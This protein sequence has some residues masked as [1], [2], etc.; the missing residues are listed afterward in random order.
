[1][2]K[3]ILKFEFKKGFSLV[4]LLVSLI[5]IS[6]VIAAFAPILTKKLNSQTLS[7]VAS[8]EISSDCHENDY[9][10]SSCAL[11]TES[12]CI[13]CPIE[14][15]EVGKF[16][17]SKKC[18][19]QNCGENPL[20]GSACLTCD[21]R[22]CTKCQFGYYIQ[23]GFC[24]ACPIGTYCDGI[25]IYTTCP[26]GYY[27]DSTH[28]FKC[29]EKYNSSC[30]SCDLTGCKKCDRYYGLSG[31]KCVLCDAGLKD[32]CFSCSTS[33]INVCDEGQCENHFLRD[34]NGQCTIKCSSKINSCL[35]CSDT[36]TCT[37][38]LYGYFINT[39]KKCTKCNISNCA[40]CKNNISADYPEC[41][42]CIGGYYLNSDKKCVS[43]K[44]KFGEN[45]ASCDEKACLSCTQDYVLNKDGECDKADTTK[46]SCSGSDFMKIGKLCFTR[47]NMGDSGNLKIPSSVTT[48]QVGGD[49]CYS[50][51]SNCCWKG[52]TASGCDSKNGSYS[53]CNRT[54]CNYSAADEICKKFNYDNRTWRVPTKDEAWNIAMLHTIGM[55]SDGLMFCD[56]RSSMPYNSYC[57]IS[58]NCNGAAY[59]QCLPNYIWTNLSLQ[60][61]AL[62]KF[63]VLFSEGYWQNWRTLMTQTASV[64]CVTDFDE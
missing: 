49:T 64:R 13:S 18:I 7:F 46:F 14:C 56:D 2:Y 24:R 33:G 29:T 47:K 48:V 19:C 40:Y 27:C 8:S 37:N 41:Q 17:N 20:Y 21:D 53:G 59:G 12:Y 54:V 31:G 30:I 16:K 11:C 61:N 38:C 36:T 4:E 25:N 42:Y 32:K 51:S 35:R 55:G 44:E 52:Q 26:A 1:M 5:V 28:M 45:C 57:S 34:S 50:S 60:D 23:N 62:R 10:S 15:D 39:N 63:V 22:Q 58:E 43:C 6:I 9:Y 3:S